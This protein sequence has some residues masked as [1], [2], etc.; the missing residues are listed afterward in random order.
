MHVRTVSLTVCAP[1]DTVFNFLADIENLPKWATDSCER[2][3]LRRGGWWALTSQGELMVATEADPVTGVIDLL[4]GS[5]P[6]HMNLLPIRVLA[7]S[8][9]ATLVSFTLIQPQEMTAEGYEQ[10]YRAL[11]AEGRGL[12]RRFGGGELHVIANEADLAAHGAN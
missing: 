8:G 3:G 5:S 9:R 4:A 10:R 1:R 2:V 6:D 11:L 12:L 7:L